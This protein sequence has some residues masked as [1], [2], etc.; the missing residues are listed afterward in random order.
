MRTEDSTKAPATARETRSSHYYYL[1]P[2]GVSFR[3]P[4]GRNISIGNWK[5]N[6][7]VET[8]PKFLLEKDQSDQKNT[9][10]KGCKG[11]V[12]KSPTSHDVLG[13]PGLKG[14]RLPCGD[15]CHNMRQQAAEKHAQQKTR[16][17]ETKTYQPVRNRT[18]RLPE[19][20]RP[21]H[22]GGPPSGHSQTGP[23]NPLWPQLTPPA[24]RCREVRCERNPFGLFDPRHGEQSPRG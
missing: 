21:R 4:E 16:V 1:F 14:G 3:L 5:S 9:S 20:Q 2:S 15:G 19:A 6:W 24:T 17:D 8:I 12:G 13:Q 11:P 18:E 7:K 22:R 23:W 10:L